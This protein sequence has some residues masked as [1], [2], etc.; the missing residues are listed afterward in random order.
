[1]ENTFIDH[2][3][4]IIIDS[5]NSFYLSK[6]LITGPLN[7]AMPYIVLK[8]LALECGVIVSLKRIKE[9]PLYYAKLYAKLA[10]FKPALL[11]NLSFADSSHKD[12]SIH[13]VNPL[14]DWDINQLKNAISF[15]YSFYNIY[16]SISNDHKKTLS[17]PIGLQ[18]SDAPYNI[19]ACILYGICRYYQV[20]LPLDI[21][22]EELKNKVL[23][24]TNLLITHLTL[25]DYRMEEEQEDQY[26][27]G[28]ESEQEDKGKQG[29]QGKQEDKGKQ[30]EQGDKINH[31]KYQFQK[32][33]EIKVVG[34]LFQDVG[35][36]QNN[37]YPLTDTQSIV[38]G[39]VVY[40]TDLS[41]Y[42]DPL[43]EFSNLRKGKQTKNKK[44]KKYQK[45][46]PNLLDLNLYF[47][48]YLPQTCYL[49]ETIKHHLQL[50]SFPIFEFIG[51]S[52]YEI[53]QELFLR[54]NFHIGWY[55]NIDTK[56]TP[57]FLENV[58]ELHP[59][60]MIV[61][62]SLY[63]NLSFTTWKELDEIFRKT[64]SFLNPF[65]NKSTFDEY[66]IQRLIKLG[67][68]IL[69]PTYDYQY[70]FDELN[71]DVENQIQSCLNT[72][73]EIFFEKQIESEGFIQYKLFFE[74]LNE[75]LKS[76]FVNT[77]NHL[78]KVCLFM[79]GWNGNPNDPFPI[80]QVPFVDQERTEK[81][82]IESIFELDEWNQKTLGEFY[83]LPLMIWKNEYIKSN[84]DDQGLTI[85][86]RI[87][88]I[89]NGENSSISSC[90]RMSSNVLGST[91][92]FYCKLFG[93]PPKFK[94]EN[95]RAIM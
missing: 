94:I 3:N 46:N 17:H 61:Y 65:E 60:E 69:K 92:C 8:E 40:L 15:L 7:P 74:N 42:E 6:F 55:P 33:D 66:K 27:K 11:S 86:Q 18:T 85:G 37:F 38:C 43:I 77:L 89:K 82:T 20:N 76:I 13:F 30:G 51:M 88:M 10:K 35:Y 16:E 34:D 39:A 64:K 63:E 48:P 50:F 67:N 87:E 9:E 71:E 54:E 24:N 78:F 81:N 62:G 25:L 41:F 28:S 90:I 80:E 14:V 45:R 2:T 70:L 21:T 56:E 83:E 59:F 73:D 58:D 36:L 79:R 52:E 68:F 26:E 57:I 47:N 4:E 84:L 72:I 19:N 49:E 31:L 44:W 29:K 23:C 53:L 32:Y 5:S 91:Y 12:I 22:Y 1:M 95:L 93:I 75:D